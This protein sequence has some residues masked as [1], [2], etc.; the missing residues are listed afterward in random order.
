[1]WIYDYE[2]MLELVE[3]EGMQRL[4]LMMTMV[5]TVTVQ[6]KVFGRWMNPVHQGVEGVV[7]GDPDDDNGSDSDCPEES[8]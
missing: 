1:M 6:K 3:E 5:V 2:N 8:I 7:V 4:T